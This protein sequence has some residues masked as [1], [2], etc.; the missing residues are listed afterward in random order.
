M[1]AQSEAKPAFGGQR[2]RKGMFRTVGQLYTEQLANH[3]SVL[4]QT[5][6]HFVHCIIPNHK[7]KVL[8]MVVLQL[9]T[10][11][12]YSTFAVFA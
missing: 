11:T 6:P 7:K 12:L 2:P 8:Y 10:Y 3:M 5:Q 9:F 4:C 1:Q